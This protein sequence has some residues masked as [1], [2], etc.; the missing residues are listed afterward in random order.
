MGTVAGLRR[1]VLQLTR[2]PAQLP[3]ARGLVVGYDASDRR[4]QVEGSLRLAPQNPQQTTTNTLDGKRYVYQATNIGITVRKRQHRARAGGGD[5]RPREACQARL[6]KPSA[7]RS[8]V[9]ISVATLQDI[10]DVEKLE[11]LRAKFLAMVSHELRCPPPPSRAPPPRPWTRPPT[12][13]GFLEGRRRIRS[14]T[15]TS[16]LP[17]RAHLQEP[18]SAAASS[19]AAR[20]RRAGRIGA[21]SLLST[22]VGRGPRGCSRL[23]GA[24]RTTARDR[25]R[26]TRRPHLGCGDR[27][28]A[29]CRRRRR[30]PRARTCCPSSSPSPGWRSRSR[31]PSSD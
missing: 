14:T 1:G 18:I 20:R 17:L 9:R 11:R 15:R 21:P 22:Q 13:L 19:R 28:L 4:A 2:S 6:S 5:R 16:R 26:A 12:Q 8:R 29:G 31:P 3:R 27:S 30:T 10:A 23:R 24:P 25:P 7:F